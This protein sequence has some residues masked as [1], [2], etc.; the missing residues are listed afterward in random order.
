MSRKDARGREAALQY[1]IRVSQA[2]ESRPTGNSR[3]GASG[4]D[5]GSESAM[6]G[7]KVM[8][9]PGRSKEKN[10]SCLRPVQIRLGKSTSRVG[11]G[12]VRIVGQ[13]PSQGSA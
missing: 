8:P 13:V 7:L 12:A 10:D 11:N 5:S 9:V 4:E 3:R 6:Q 2:W 1:A